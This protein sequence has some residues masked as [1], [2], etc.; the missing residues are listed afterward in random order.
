MSFAAEIKMNYLHTTYRSRCC[1]R[2]F[3]TGILVAAARHVEGDLLSLQTTDDALAGEIAELFP[4]AFPSADAEV[5]RVSRLH[6]AVRVRDKG[7]AS[8]LTAL[9]TKPAAPVYLPRCAT[10]RTAY[11]RGLFVGAGRVSDPSADCHMEFAFGSR[12][13]RLAGQLA[14]MGLRLRSGARG[15]ELLLYAK[16]NTDI[17]D[18]FGM[19]E[20]TDTYFALMNSRIEREIRNG[21]NRVANC[22]AN[23]ITKVVNAA[24]VQLD[25]LLYLERGH[26]L[27]SL[28]SELADTARLRLAHPE[29]SLAQLAS[30]A[31]PPISKPGLSHRLRRLVAIADEHKKKA[32]EVQ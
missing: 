4:S 14:D 6:Y 19:V 30:I 32:E 5:E 26:L 2:S 28:P 22:E 25:A 11:L 13:E 21:A 18:F 7:L 23:N 17:Q 9:D 29:L 24:A 12:C 16:N 1:R 31:S 3:V 27:E 10:C 20:D 8:H 15:R